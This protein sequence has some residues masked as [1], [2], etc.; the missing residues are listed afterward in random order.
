[1]QLIS[2]INHIQQLPTD[3]LLLARNP[4]K[5][6]LECQPILDF[7]PAMV[8][9]LTT[10]TKMCKASVKSLLSTNISTLGSYKGQTPLIINNNTTPTCKAP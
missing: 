8:V 9:A 6:A 3:V 7:A 10:G 1:M 5:P 4:G 2:L